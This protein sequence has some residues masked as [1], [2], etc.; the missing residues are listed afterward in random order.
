[1]AERM[2]L[3]QRP[4]KLQVQLIVPHGSAP[5]GPVAARQHCQGRHSSCGHSS[6]LP[7]A[8]LTGPAQQEGAK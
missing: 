8:A 1:M 7:I 4:V 2:V 5:V 6:H 3:E